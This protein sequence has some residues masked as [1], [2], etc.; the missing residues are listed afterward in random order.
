MRSNNHKVV[1][2]YCFIHLRC[3]L[4]AKCCRSD[5]DGVRTKLLV[6]YTV[7]KKAVVIRIISTLACGSLHLEIIKTVIMIVCFKNH[8]RTYLC[9]IGELS[10]L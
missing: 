7:T 5:E 1:V 9:S 4:S 10:T 2:E 3:I 8:R 6:C